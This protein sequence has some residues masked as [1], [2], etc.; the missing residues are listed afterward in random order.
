[1]KFVVFGSNIYLNLVLRQF[2]ESLSA[3]SSDWQSLLLFYVIPTGLCK[4]LPIVAAWGIKF[5]T[6]LFMACLLD[7]KKSGFFWRAGFLSANQSFLKT[8]QIALIGWIKAGHS[9]KSLLF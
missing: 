1:V 5:E 7:Q 4:D 3:R 2:V 9:K 6:K 8:F